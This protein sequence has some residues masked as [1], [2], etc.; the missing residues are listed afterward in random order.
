MSISGFSTRESLM[1]QTLRIIKTIVRGT[2]LVWG[3]IRRRKGNYG[4]SD[5]IR[6]LGRGGSSKLH[7][8]DDYDCAT[9]LARTRRKI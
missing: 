6:R 5:E 7:E 9:G 3:W 1:G 4:R 8:D 2:S